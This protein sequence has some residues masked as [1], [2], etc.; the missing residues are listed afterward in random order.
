[1]RVVLHRDVYSDV[2][3]I[4]DYY[5][6]VAG[7]NLADDFYEEPRSFMVKATNHPMRFRIYERDLRRVNLKRFPYHFLFRVK[8]ERLRVLV[9]R[10]NSR[11]PSFG[12]E[13]SW[14]P[15]APSGGGE[16]CSDV[17]S[18]CPQVDHTLAPTYHS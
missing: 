7:P 12:L 13:R 17:A 14:S 11:H 5:E 3:E 2:S 6:R 10:H 8:G 16:K 15:P 9:V 1:M 4:M 18:A